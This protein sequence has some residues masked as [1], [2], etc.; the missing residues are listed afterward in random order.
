KLGRGEAV[1]VDV[2]LG[3]FLVVDH[4]VHGDPRLARPAGMRRVAGVADQVARVGSGHWRGSRTSSRR[5]R[6]PDGPG[7]HSFVRLS[8]LRAAG[9]VDEAYR[10]AVSR[11]GAPDAA[12]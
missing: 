6:E 5:G 10:R 9:P 12:D 3:A 8:R 1:V 4:E 2:V 11:P 7:R